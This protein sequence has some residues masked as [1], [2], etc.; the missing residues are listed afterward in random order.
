MK[1]VILSI[2]IILT[3]SAAGFSQTVIKQGLDSIVCPKRYKCVYSYDAMGNVILAVSYSWDKATNSWVWSSEEKYAYDDNG[4]LTMHINDSRKKATNDREKQNCKFENR[5]YKFENTYDGNNLIIQNHYKWDNAT[6]D[7]AISYRHEYAYDTNGNKTIEISY[8]D[9]DKTT[10]DWISRYK[11]EYAYDDNGNKTIEISYGWDN[12]WIEKYK[13]KYEY[14]YDDSGNKIMYIIYSWNNATGDWK[15]RQKYEYT[16][17]ANNLIIQNKYEWVKFPNI[18]R[19]VYVSRDEFTYDTNGNKTMSA[20]YSEYND[21]SLYDT[22]GSYS[23]EV[24][25]TYYADSLSPKDKYDFIYDNNGNITIQIEYRWGMKTNNW[26]KYSKNEYKYD[27]KGNQIMKIRYFWYDDANIWE[28]S[29]KEESMFDL[30]YSKTDLVMPDYIDDDNMQT[31]EIKYE[32]SGKKWKQNEVTSYYW[33]EKAI[34]KNNK[35]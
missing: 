11:S 23:R 35:K 27:N 33:S 10:D 32:W 25:Y 7:W 12:D 2:A 30:S 8:H 21:E 9:L 20:S 24:Y 3:A 18:N 15:G 22:N 4:N 31:K 5:A 19:W 14:T 26:I 13:Y 29:Y 28:K 1:K 16:Y 34:T 6:N 17:N